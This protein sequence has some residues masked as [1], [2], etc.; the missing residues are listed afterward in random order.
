V[1][2]DV[3][4]EVDRFFLGAPVIHIYIDNDFKASGVRSVY[5]V[6]TK[7]IFVVSL[8]DIVFATTGI[9]KILA[10]LNRSFVLSLCENLC[11]F[12]VSQ[13]D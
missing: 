9:F 1:N 4:L 5:L 13:Y 8:D 6:T 3:D 12:C 10:V 2:L 7:D 11:N